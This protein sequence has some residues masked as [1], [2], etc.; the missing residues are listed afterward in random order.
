MR[1]AL[2]RPSDGVKG[3]RNALLVFLEEVKNAP[4]RDAGTVVELPAGRCRRG[5]S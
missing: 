5:K 3:D 4:N 1:V 2:E